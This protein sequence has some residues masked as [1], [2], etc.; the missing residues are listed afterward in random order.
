MTP[1]K[2]KTPFTLQEDSNEAQSVSEDRPTWAV[3]SPVWDGVLPF[4]CSSASFD[5]L[6]ANPW[7]PMIL[8][9]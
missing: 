9:N 8:H 2:G 1:R 7:A 6:S 4:S 5:S 3:V